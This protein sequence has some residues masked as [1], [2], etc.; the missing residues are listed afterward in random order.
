MRFVPCLALIVA[1]ACV[2]AS[3][4]DEPAPVAE[5][6]AV[7][8]A[9]DPVRSPVLCPESAAPGF[10]AAQIAREVECHVEAR[11]GSAPVAELR[12][13]GSALMATYHAGLPRPVQRPDGS[14]TYEGPMANALLVAAGTW[15]GWK[16]GRAQPLAPAAAAEVDRILADPAF[17]REEAYVRPTCT[18][19]GARRLVVRHGARRAVRQQSCGGRGLT[20][21]LFDIVLAG[22]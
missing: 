11:L 15:R 7:Q 19:A 21:R 1:A 20:G 10:D 9:R 17:W 12:S 3:P 8:P 22:P 6:D 16:S 13:A 2:H 4:E 18:D 5:P 14:W